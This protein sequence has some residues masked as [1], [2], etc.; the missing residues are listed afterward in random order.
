MR[1]TQSVEWGR[2][3]LGLRRG[4]W[5]GSKMGRRGQPTQYNGMCTT[6]MVAQHMLSIDIYRA[7][8]FII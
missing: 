7:P 1:W 4:P 3:P 6:P 5:L 8:L 2:A